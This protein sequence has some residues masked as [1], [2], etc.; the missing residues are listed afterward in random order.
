M[1][2]EMQTIVTLHDAIAEGRRSLSIAKG[3]PGCSAMV[4]P[5]TLELL[6]K[7]AE[8]VHAGSTQAPERERE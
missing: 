4:L 2:T 5:H 6:L 8:Q 1:T 3:H 7:A